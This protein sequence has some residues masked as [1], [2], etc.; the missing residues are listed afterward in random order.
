M[1][2]TW[3]YKDGSQFRGTFAN[4][5]PVMGAYYFSR[6]SLVQR[7]GFRSGPMGAYWKPGDSMAIGKVDELHSLYAAQIAT[8]K[9]WEA[10]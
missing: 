10:Q 8:A 7:G 4:L 9:A 3:V 5:A 6:S 1:D 2:G